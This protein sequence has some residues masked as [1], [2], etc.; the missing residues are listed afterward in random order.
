MRTKSIKERN[1][2]NQVGKQCYACKVEDHEIKGYKKS[3]NI[4]LR[5]TVN[6][7]PSTREKKEK[8]EQYG[9]VIS[10]RNRKKVNMSNDRYKAQLPSTK[11]S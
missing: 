7:Y 8:M 2:A 11:H 3:R 10:I 4:S 5:Y 1:E 9:T 6:R